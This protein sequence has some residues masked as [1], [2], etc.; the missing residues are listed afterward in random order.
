MAD[1]VLDFFDITRCAC[2]IQKANQGIMPD[3]VEE[4]KALIISLFAD[5]S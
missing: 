2:L 3:I 5:L 4:I 1:E